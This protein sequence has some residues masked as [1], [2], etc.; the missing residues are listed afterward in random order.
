M[1]LIPLNRL[2]DFVP[3]KPLG[4]YKDCESREGGCCS[5]AGSSLSWHSQL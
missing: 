4:R 3:S 1:S 2:T 5:L